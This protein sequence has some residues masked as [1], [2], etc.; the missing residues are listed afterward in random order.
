MVWLRTD[1]GLGAGHA[2]KLGQAAVTGTHVLFFDADVVLTPDIVAL[3]HD[4]DSMAFD[5]CLFPYHDS[6]LQARGPAR[7][8]R[9]TA[10]IGPMW[11]PRKSRICW[12]RPKRWF[13]AA[14][15]IIR[16]TRS[17]ARIFCAMPLSAAP[18][19]RCTTISSRIGQGSFQAAGYW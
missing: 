12:A 13:Y 8:C 2:R 9:Q 10:P 4:L 11:P 7:K 18:R 5:F 16:G 6:Q 15:R 1:A 3:L 19:S 17:G 14:F